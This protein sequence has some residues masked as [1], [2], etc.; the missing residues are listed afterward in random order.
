MP[1]SSY[2]YH[3]TIKKYTICF[4][5]I[6]NNITIKR[7]NSAGAVI[8]TQRVPIQN[9]PKQKWFVRSKAEPNLEKKA[10]I[11]LPAMGFEMVSMSYNPQRK[12]NTVENYVKTNN[13][14]KNYMDQA[15]SPVPYD[16]GFDLYIMAKNRD[17][18]SQIIEQIIPFFRPEL[19]VKIKIMETELGITQDT[20]FILNSINSELIYE[21]NFENKNSYVYTLNFTCQGN[22]YGPVS[23]EPI[24]KTI[25]YDVYLSSNT[26]ETAT[27]IAANTPDIE[28]NIT[29]GLLAN[30]SPTTNSTLSVATSEIAVEDDYGFCRD[31][32]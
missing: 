13:T 3:E 17:D 4:G 28:M 25:N 6:F 22:F 21:G 8:Q 7:T 2:F 15:F 14:N 1:I 23:T 20:P 12:L 10:S 18:M 27:T 5:T 26:E 24:I 32:T 30:G 9:M 29:P 16:L 19:N 11:T 31:I